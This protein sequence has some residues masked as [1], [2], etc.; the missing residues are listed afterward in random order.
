MWSRLSASISNEKFTAHRYPFSHLM[1]FSTTAG[2]SS[3]RMHALRDT[4]SHVWAPRWM[5]P[6]S[7]EERPSRALVA[8]VRAT[9]RGRDAREPHAVRADDAGAEEARLGQPFDAR[10]APSLDGVRPLIRRLEQMDVEPDPARRR[11]LPNR[12]EKILG[13]AVGIDR[14][15]WTSTSG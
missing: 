3:G 5:I 7:R 6:R 1:G 12:A 15:N 13:T 11:P 14:G 8:A 2:S 4:C 10:L 9:R